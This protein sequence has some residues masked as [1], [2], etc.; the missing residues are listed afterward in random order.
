MEN[1]EAEYRKLN[2][3]QRLAVDTLE[4]PLLVVAGPGTGKTQLLGMRVANILKCTDTYPS[5]I[6]CLTFTNKAAA[7]MRERLVSLIGADAHSVQVKT[8][9]SFAADVMSENPDYFWN[10]APLVSAPDAVGLGIVQDILSSLPLDNPLALQY[11]GMY[12]AVRDVQQG[13][14]L[15]KEAGLTPEKLR[16]LIN[17]NLAYIDVIEPLMADI[18]SA[19]LSFKKLDDIQNQ[20]DS[21]PRQST[22]KLITPLLPLDSVLR[23][24]LA[25]A[26]TQDQKIHKTSNTG[27][28]KRRWIQNIGGTKLMY[29]ERRRNEWW[30]NLADVYEQYRSA[31]SQRGYYDYADMLVEVISQLENSAELRANVQEQ[32]LYVLI[33]E[34]QDT[35]AAQ[36]RLSHLV[37]DQIDSDDAPNLM[38][39]GDDD[40]SIFKF[41]GAELN[42]MLSFQASYPS[43]QLIVLT[44]NYRSSQEVLDTAKTVIEQAKDRLVNREP[45]LVKDL[46]AKNPGVE[47]GFIQHQI[48]P[49]KEHQYQLVAEEISRRH[50]AE[51]NQTIAVLARS[52]DSLRSL[53]AALINQDVAVRYE[54]QQNITENEAVAQVI[55]MG[56]AVQAIASGNDSAINPAVAQLVRHPMW[57]FG[58]M[59]LWELATTNFSQP[60]WLASLLSHPDKQVAALGRFLMW[61]SSEASYQPLPVMMEYMIGLRPG[62][63]MSSPLHDYF[64]KYRKTTNAYLQALSAIHKLR[65]LVTEFCK[66]KQASLADFNEF[67]RLNQSNQKVITDETWF[68][69]GANAVDLL[70]VHKAKGLEFDTVFVLD[71]VESVWQPRKSGRKP[72]ANLPL[73]PYGDD[74]DDYVR[75]MYVAITRA[76]HSIIITSYATNESGEPVLPTPFIHTVPA[77]SIA[78]LE[79]PST[80]TALE[81]AI[82]W[83]RLETA[84]EYEMLRGRLDA[85]QLSNT[86]MI[87]FLDVTNGGP[88]HYFEKNLL[89]LPDAKSP[90]MAYGTAAHRAMEIAQKLVNTKKFTLAQVLAAYQDSLQEQFLPASEHARY[91]AHGQKMLEKLFTDLDYDLPAGSLPEQSFRDIGIGEARLSG[92]ADRIDL[93]GSDLII[94]DYKTG[95]PLNSFATKDKNR[96]VK[97]WRH[98]TQLIFYTLLVQNSSRYNKVNH[99]TGQMVYLEAESHAQLIR[100]YQATPEELQQL[101]ELIQ[102]VWQHIMG[103]SFPSTDHYPAGMVGIQAFIKD[104]LAKKI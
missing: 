23:E 85:Y 18:L 14:K 15:A 33:D 88:Q 19:P 70:S 94:A 49:T 90:N 59:T 61:L 3:R 66:G 13:L 92:T 35:N 104:L 83:P 52:H 73:Q 50:K 24:S 69:S 12:T 95:K 4:G 17:A 76:K 97:A 48:Y 1:Y 79:E 84:D 6:L 67:I 32:F 20:T 53:A 103:L 5:S 87:N 51:P 47:A 37:A 38:A 55:L 71:A 22:D 25:F 8:F 44:D 42:N 41:N 31:L 102:V 93:Q 58:A 101:A 30:L 64:I 62:E 16:A 26:I 86:H 54:Q 75:L 43:A 98:R 40:Q 2:S 68:V 28:W 82:Q 65:G 77:S 74:Y 11:G 81:R 29:D 27:A 36:L 57:G 99:I 96:Q 63:H 45:S 60:N 34:F 10:G 80:I 100:E 91:L 56:Q 39:V 72:P 7:N 9:H 21:L 78:L 46:V 89:K